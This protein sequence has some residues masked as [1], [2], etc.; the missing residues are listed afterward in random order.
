M[1]QFANWFLLV[2]IWGCAPVSAMASDEAGHSATDPVQIDLWQA[3]FTIV[4]FVLLLLILSRFAFKPILAGLQNREEFIRKS[5]SDA[6][7]ASKKAQLQLAEYTRQLEHARAEATTIV[8]E[9]RRDAERVKQEIHHSAE[10]EKANMI[11]QAR[12]EIKIASD[13]AVRDLYELGARLATDVAGRVIGKE[14]SPADHERLI[15]QSI[16]QLGKLNVDRN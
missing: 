12:R 1:K 14:L 8:E 16:E 15:E 6:E 2:A 3:A 10:K 11:E 7:D 5:L 13:T 4:V 9:G